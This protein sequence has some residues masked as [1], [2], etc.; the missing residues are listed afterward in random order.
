MR[1]QYHF[2]KSDH[3]LQVWDVG[4]LI[5]LT[6]H[7]K[8]TEHPLSDIREL[9]EPYW[10]DLEGDR[11]TCKSIAEHMCLVQAADLSW[12]IIIC[13]AGRVMDGMHRVVKA[14]LEGHKFLL[15]YRLPV[16]PEP[17]YVGVHPDDLSYD[18][19][20]QGV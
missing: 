12:P 4:N 13:P 2:R 15:A 6:A 17:D 1:K 20:G 19:A 7:L 18:E 3:G 9:D 10:Y 11:P 14:F 5:R 16:L 8:A